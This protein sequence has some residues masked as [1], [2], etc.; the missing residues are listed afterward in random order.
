[1]ISD[2]EVLN[3]YK[4]IVS[5]I[6]SICGPSCEVVLHDIRNP[7]HSVIA[8]ENGYQTKRKIGSPLTD[9]AKASIESKA[10]LDQDYISNYSGTT[11]GKQ[12]LSSTLYIKNN[13]KLI[14]MLCCNRDTS[15]VI[16]LENAL[17]RVAHQY[18]LV[19]RSHDL[20]ENLDEQHDS[21]VADAI[22]EIIENYGGIAMLKTADKVQIVRELS[23]KGILAMKGAVSEAARQLNVSVP[24]VY[25]YMHK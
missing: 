7:E 10:Y 11:K 3:M 17:K 16:D 2:D 19:V 18:N 12:F 15:V 13:G 4:P 14:G 8:I 5:F 20:H 25:R 24:T 9:F 21:I 1:M 6:A 22:A 23:K